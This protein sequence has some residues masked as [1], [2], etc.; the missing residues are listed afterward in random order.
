[1][2]LLELSV[3]ASQECLRKRTSE[4]KHTREQYGMLHR[5]QV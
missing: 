5:G 1:M 4:R 2:F 3:N